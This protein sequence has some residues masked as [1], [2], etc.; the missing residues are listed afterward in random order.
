M[1]SVLRDASGTQCGKLRYHV[2]T[3][4]KLTNFYA[5]DTRWTRSAGINLMGR[6]PWELSADART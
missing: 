4:Y 5:Q 2:L 3:C 1:M 6:D